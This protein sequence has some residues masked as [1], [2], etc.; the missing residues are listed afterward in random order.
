MGCFW[1]AKQAVQNHISN[2]PYSIQVSYDT[3][4]KAGPQEGI[5]EVLLNTPIE[6]NPYAAVMVKVLLNPQ[7]HVAQGPVSCPVAQQVPGYWESVLGSDTST[8]GVGTVSCGN[9]KGDASLA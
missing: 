2:V 4:L 7:P 1:Q 3:S 6:A 9:L 8:G 5:A